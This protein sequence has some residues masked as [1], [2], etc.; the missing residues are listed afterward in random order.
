MMFKKR[1]LLI[2]CALV[3]G[4]QQ[5]EPD[6]VVLRSVRTIA[7]GQDLTK[8]HRTFNGQAETDRVIDLSF[9]SSGIITKFDIRLGQQVEKGDL[10]AELD[11]VQARLAYE[12]ALS[13]LNSAE[14]DRNTKKLSLD[15][16]QALY[17][18]GSVSLSDYEAAKN[19]YRTANATYKSAQRSVDIQQEQIEYGR[20]F[21]PENGVIAQVNNDIDENVSPGQTVAVLNA[22]TDMEIDVG[23]PESVINQVQ[24]NAKV[25]V[26]FAALPNEWFTGEV[27]EISPSLDRSTATY[28]VR[29]R[30]LGA[31]EKIRAGMA[32]TVDFQ[33]EQ[34]QQ[35]TTTLSVPAGAVGEDEKGNF[36]FTVNPQGDGTA[37]IKKQAV[38]LG[39]LVGD[40]FEVESGL[41]VG[42]RVVVAGVHSVLDGQQVKLED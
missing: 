7:V 41:A 39:E 1:L 2:A 35:N 32:A 4:C 19:G 42:D 20:I 23:L 8:A 21:A 14:S 33:F 25:E 28:P 3:A 13:S 30:L 29:I 38:A 5:A 22:G 31:T 24:P 17:E 36:V 18:K 34:A 9:R 40:L 15:R 6:E 11:N 37:T 12:Q 26:T 16:I 27:S 10:L